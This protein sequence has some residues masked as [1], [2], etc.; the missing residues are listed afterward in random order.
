MRQTFSQLY[1]THVMLSE[2]LQ[3]NAKH[4]ARLSNISGSHFVMFVMNDQRS[5]ASLKMTSRHHFGTTATK[6]RTGFSP[7]IDNALPSSRA[8]QN[9]LEEPPSR[10]IAPRIF[11]SAATGTVARMFANCPSETSE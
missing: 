11:E 7:E 10:F 9:A 1:K 8:N 6:S 4:E 3:R 2:A 5:F